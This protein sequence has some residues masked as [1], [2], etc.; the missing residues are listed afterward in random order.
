M[1][2]TQDIK[3]R[4][5]IPEDYPDILRLAKIP[6]KVIL[7]DEEFEEEQIAGLFELAL[8]NEE[9]TGIVLTVNE[10]VR[11]FIFGYIHRHYFH[12]KSMA[13]CMAIF[14]EPEYRKYGFEMLKAFEA[15]G[16][17]KQV[18]TLSISTFANLSPKYL[19]KL[20]KRLGYSE[21]EVT[22]WKEL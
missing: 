17:Y 12:S 2:H 5:T 9:F 20:Y 11:G 8:K 13:Y 14:V 16:R 6:V 21:K 7:P 22:H 19:G 4:Y 3:I 1:V 18:K 10:T 15:W